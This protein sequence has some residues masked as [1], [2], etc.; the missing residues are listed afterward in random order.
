MLLSIVNYFVA[1]HC[2]AR[3]LGVGECV[4]ELYF[5]PLAIVGPAMNGSYFTAVSAEFR[6]RKELYNAKDKA[7]LANCMSLLNYADSGLGF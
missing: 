1:D 6:Y 5:W 3:R 7:H 4:I 2:L